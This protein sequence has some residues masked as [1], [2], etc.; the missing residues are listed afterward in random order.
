MS[1]GRISGAKVIPLQQVAI[2]RET[3]VVPQE[4]EAEAEAEAEDRRAFSQWKFWWGNGL[5]MAPNL[6]PMVKLVGLS[7]LFHV[8]RKDGYCYPSQEL[9]AAELGV[10]VR[11][12][13]NAVARLKETRWIAVERTNRTNHYRPL[14][15]HVDGVYDLYDSH[16]Q[17]LGEERDR[18]RHSSP[19]EF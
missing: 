8:N 14:D 16:R 12:I 5:R 11:T 3:T 1:S 18:K 6:I 7:L 9:L 15:T 4:A 19:S 17:R 10:D 2:A 13:R